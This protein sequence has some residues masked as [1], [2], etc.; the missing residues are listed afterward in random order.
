[1]QVV[2]TASAS[3][4]N[5]FIKLWFDHD[6]I[7]FSFK[8]ISIS[9]RF[10]QQKEHFPNPNWMKSVYNYHPM[11]GSI[12]I[13]RCW[14]WASTMSML[15][16]AHY[17]WGAMKP[18]GLINAS[19]YPNEDGHRTELLVETSFEIDEKFNQWTFHENPTLEHVL[20]IC[21]NLEQIHRSQGHKNR[22]FAKRIIDHWPGYIWHPFHVIL[23]SNRWKFI[24]Q[25]NMCSAAEL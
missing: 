2:S 9:C 23:S 4:C 16:W 21:E 1:M 18:F 22:Q 15:S 8:W 7:F 11:N 13:N 14:A 3:C 25:F 12:H 24:F 20:L 10:L 5:K 19:E 6:T 17:N